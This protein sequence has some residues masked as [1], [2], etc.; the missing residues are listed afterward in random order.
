MYPGAERLGTDC[1]GA[2][3][4]RTTRQGLEALAT[5]GGPGYWNT[6]S[7]KSAGLEGLVMPGVAWIWMSLVSLPSESKA[8]NEKPKVYPGRGLSGA[9]SANGMATR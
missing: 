8:R 3:R 7:R 2:E 5:G 9:R 4:L 6:N 1:A